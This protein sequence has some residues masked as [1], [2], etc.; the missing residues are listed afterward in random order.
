MRIFLALVIV[1][2][3]G[4]SS[5][6]T[7]QE[8]SS[9]DDNFY[10]P[11]DLVIKRVELGDI[12]AV[13]EEKI[14][15]HLD[16]MH[17]QN[18]GV[19]PLGKGTRLRITVPEPDL[20]IAKKCVTYGEES[21]LLSIDPTTKIDQR[22]SRM[23]YLSVAQTY[24]A[25]AA[26]FKAQL[27]LR[28]LKIPDSSSGM[29]IAVHNVLAPIADCLRARKIIKELETISSHRQFREDFTLKKLVGQLDPTRHTAVFE[30]LKGGT[31]SFTSIK[32]TWVPS[33]DYDAIRTRLCLDP[34]THDIADL[35]CK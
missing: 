9:L 1:C 27:R 30:A 16:R 26:F 31:P 7:G 23:D 6:T 21:G 8:S 15:G 5:P 19:K 4:C 18:I 2:A 28:G 14:L 10:I 24:Y 32:G 11:K 22:Y 29:N 13:D 33:A 12:L 17:I 35:Q 20:D 34:D 3:V 25:D